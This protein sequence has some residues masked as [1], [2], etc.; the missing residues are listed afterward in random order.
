[1]TF[2]FNN[3]IPNQL[4]QRAL[5]LY[6]QVNVDHN[7]SLYAQDKWTTRNLTASYGIRYDYF[8]T[9]FPEQTA[10]PAI[11][12]P[13]RNITFPAQDNL[14]WH[15]L[16][17]RLGAAYDVLGNG[18][19]AIKV[20]LNRYLQNEAA[21]SPLAARTEPAQHAGHVDHSFLERC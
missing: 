12:A 21:G 5:P 2:R 1:M 8:G 3:G 16:S 9:G 7:L 17:P 18:K 6:G 14:S 15:D 11:L 20:S 19:T 10:G 13:T 4:T